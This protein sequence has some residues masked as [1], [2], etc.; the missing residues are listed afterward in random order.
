MHTS[1]HLVAELA[2]DPRPW[3]VG[4]QERTLTSHSFK[5]QQACPTLDLSCLP[6]KVP[7]VTTGQTPRLRQKG[8]GGGNTPLETMLT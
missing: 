7:L 2:G 1:S 5:T 4:S 8:A 3:T 6:G